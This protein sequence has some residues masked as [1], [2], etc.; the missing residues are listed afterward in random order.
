MFFCEENRFET[1]SISEFPIGGGGDF[2]AG[3]VGAIEQNHIDN[4]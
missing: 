2:I 4:I 1:R 3:F